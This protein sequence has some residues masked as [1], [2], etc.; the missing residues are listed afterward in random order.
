MGF[1]IGAILGLASSLVG[2]NRKPSGTG[3]ALA[4]LAGSLGS[5]LLTN[6]GAMRRQALADRKNVEFWRMQNQYNH[7][8]AQM[9]RLRQAGLNPNLIYGSSVA[10]AT[11]SAS[12]VAPSKAAPYAI[13]NPVPSTVMSAQA[14]T[15]IGLQKAQAF[16][17]LKQAATS[18]ATKKAIDRKL[19]IEVDNLQATGDSLKQKALQEVLITSKLKKTTR[20]E[21]A[22][23][24]QKVIQ[25]KDETSRIKA[26]AAFKKKLYDNNI[27][28]NAGLGSLLMQAVTGGVVDL[29][30]MFGQIKG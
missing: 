11:G 15:Q 8:T 18:E 26:E 6:R 25:A 22:I 13:N 17:Q 21:I 12:S 7:P 5:S 29:I 24:A 10:G 23:S 30:D 27:N 16:N 2:R 20:D 28:P 19:P 3:N 9:E 1:P 4:G 14:G